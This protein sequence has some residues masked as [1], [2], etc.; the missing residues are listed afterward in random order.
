MIA[1]YPWK[2]R[3]EWIMEFNF[4]QRSNGGIWYH[5]SF[6]KTSDEWDMIAFI[7]WSDKLD[8]RYGIV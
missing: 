2:D 8:V 3:W 7:T 5:L 4:E 1:F 6:E